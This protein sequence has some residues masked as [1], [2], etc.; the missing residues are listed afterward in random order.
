MNIS[1]NTIKEIF[2]FIS[3]VLMMIGCGVAFGVDRGYYLVRDSFANRERVIMKLQADKTNL[4]KQL[5]ESHE[6]TALCIEL[7]EEK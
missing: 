4:E 7:L 5:E 6:R 1:W 3:M 2:G